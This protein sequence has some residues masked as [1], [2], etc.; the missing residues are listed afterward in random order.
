MI[1][2]ESSFFSGP[3]VLVRGKYAGDLPDTCVPGTGAFR[4]KYPGCDEFLLYFR[5]FEILRFD[6]HNTGY[7]VAKFWI[8]SNRVAWPP[9]LP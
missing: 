8:D 4:S 3:H 5:Y 7:V 6:M 9:G 1:D 2:V